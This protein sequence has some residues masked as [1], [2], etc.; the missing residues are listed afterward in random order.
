M[1]KESLVAGKED[2]DSLLLTPP[3]PLVAVQRGPV[4]R[5]RRG[6]P[7]AARVFGKGYAPAESPSPSSLSPISCALCRRR[8]CAQ[9]ELYDTPSAH[10]QRLRRTHLYASLASRVSACILSFKR[11]TSFCS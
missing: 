7:R 3:A 8:E 11:S 5:P 1:Q 10:N 6:Q 9:K 4:R 2:M